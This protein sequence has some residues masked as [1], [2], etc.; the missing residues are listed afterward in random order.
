MTAKSESELTLGR[1]VY[2]CVLRNC[3]DFGV[4][5]M[6]LKWKKPFH[7]LPLTPPASSLAPHPSLLAPHPLPLIPHSLQTENQ[8]CKKECLTAR[9]LHYIP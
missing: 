8:T 2:I 3:C 6:A 7:L 1:E 5:E 9:I 4:M